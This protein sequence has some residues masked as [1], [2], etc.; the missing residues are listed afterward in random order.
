MVSFFLRRVC[1]LREQLHDQLLLDR[2]L[3]VL[4]DGEPAYGSP[5]FVRVQLEPRWHRR[6][7]GREIVGDALLHLGDTPELH[8]LAHL[9]DVGGHGDL[10]PAHLDVTVGDHL[11]PFASRGRHAQPEHNVVESSLEQLEEVLAG[12][13]LLGL[14]PGEV[15]PE[16]RFLDAVDSLGLLLLPELDPVWRGFAAPE[17]ML[18]GRIVSPLDG[19]LLSEAACALQ[20]ELDPF[21]P[22]QPAHRDVISRHARSSSTLVAAWAADNRCAG[23]GSRRGSP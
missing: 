10:A 15:A 6:T 13:A 7:P 23:S 8:D 20:K 5:L 1:L 4:A 14:R 3:D 21:T 2:D 18:A 9:H 19:A 17:S 22:A 11:T 16:L 12:H